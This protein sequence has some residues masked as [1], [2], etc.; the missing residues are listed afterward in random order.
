MPETTMI[1]HSLVSHVILTI[2]GSEFDEIFVVPS[3]NENDH[4][5]KFER[6]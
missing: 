5:V 6:K 1:I 4:M 2:A 3:C